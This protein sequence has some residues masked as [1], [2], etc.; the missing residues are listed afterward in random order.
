MNIRSIVRDVWA[1]FR[2]LPQWVQLW[3]VFWL[4]PI[5]VASLAFVSEPMGLWI[6][7][8]ANIAMLL[9]VPVMIYERRMSRTMALPHLP[10]WTLLVILIVAINP[11][12]STTY[13]KY[14]W[15]LCATNLIS[16]AFDYIDAIHWFKG[17]RG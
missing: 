17:D 13:G 4:I 16:L 1:S 12:F 8:L 5:N 15:V 14:L 7:F 9:N 10:F 6:A 11:D 2:S 3:M